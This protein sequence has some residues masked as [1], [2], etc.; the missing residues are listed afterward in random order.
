MYHHLVI[1]IPFFLKKKKTKSFGE[2][3]FEKDIDVDQH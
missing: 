3:F 2:I 1:L